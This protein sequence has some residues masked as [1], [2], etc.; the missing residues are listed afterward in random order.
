MKKKWSKTI[1]RIILVF[2]G[3]IGIGLVFVAE[4]LGSL[5]ELTYIAI[6]C[7]VG[8]ILG[9]FIMGTIFPFANVKV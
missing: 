1:T 2:I 8:N 9:V 7:C 5:F 6:G 3:V 4:K